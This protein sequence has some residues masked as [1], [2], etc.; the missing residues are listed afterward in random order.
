MI[1]AVVIL[2]VLFLLAMI[3]LGVDFQ[4]M[5]STVTVWIKVLFV[6]I[7]VYPQKR[8]KSSGKSKEEPE[9]TD[10]IESKGKE[11]SPKGK[12]DVRDIIKILLR[13]ARRLRKRLTVGILMLHYT[14]AGDDP[15]DTALQYGRVSAAVGVLLPEICN[16]FRVKR[17]D[18]AVNVDFDSGKPMLESKITIRL[19]V[20]QL[21]YVVVAALIDLFKARSEG[22]D[23][24]QDEHIYKTKN[25]S[26]N[27]V[28][29]D[30]E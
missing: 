21:V 24:A 2:L 17:K 11:K 5:D 16:I 8:K 28:T 30:G 10:E 15:C 29:A 23:N 18:V 3:W 13:A 26:T 9:K 22:T 6:R 25:E 7:K 19:F 27:K 20:W 4:Y 1:I 14:V 12:R